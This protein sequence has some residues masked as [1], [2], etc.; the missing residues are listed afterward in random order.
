MYNQHAVVNII[1]DFLIK[2]IT[3]EIS[4]YRS[5]TYTVTGQR[6]PQNFNY[7]PEYSIVRALGNYIKVEVKNMNTNL[8]FI[9]Y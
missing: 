3:T 4:E 1:G 7:L 5:G 6:E 8:I 9:S 2:H